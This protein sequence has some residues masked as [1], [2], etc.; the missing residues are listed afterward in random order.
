MK[1][2]SVIFF[3]SLTAALSQTPGSQLKALNDCITDDCGCIGEDVDCLV[4]KESCI[5][6]CAYDLFQNK[7]LNLSPKILEISR[8]K[9]DE[10]FV[11]HVNDCYT[12]SLET[13]CTVI[14]KIK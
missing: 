6:D 7:N 4:F 1:L 12:K 5:K 9:C 14:H 13:V 3:T 8:D 2:V 10:F 11:K